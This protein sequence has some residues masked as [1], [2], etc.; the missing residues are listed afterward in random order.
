[1]EFKYC[2]NCGTKT[3]KKDALDDGMVN[4]CP[5]CEEYLF[6]FMYSAIITTVINEL[7]EVVLIKQ[8][9]I[10]NGNY[11]VLVAGYN[12]P[13]ENFE[14]TCIR[15]VKEEVGQEVHTLQYLKSY[16][17]ERKDQVMVGFISRVTKQE[18]ILSKEVSSASW[19]TLDE[20][21]N[22]VISGTIAHKLL[23]KTKEYLENNA[24]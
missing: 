6:D 19:H 1:M 14:T 10:G 16:Y 13:G 23:Q 9:H 12:V 5:K 20:A 2:L 3:I 22:L 24:K 17:F 11:Y 8:P 21:L 15:E 7:N 18:F 4:Y